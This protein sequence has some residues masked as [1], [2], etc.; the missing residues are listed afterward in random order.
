[1]SHERSEHR[2]S[3]D[4]RFPATSRRLS[5]YWESGQPKALGTE[6]QL[7]SRLLVCKPELRQSSA[8]ATNMAARVVAA[9]PAQAAGLP[10][11]RPPRAAF[12]TAS[13][14][15]QRQIQARQQH[16]MKVRAQCA[17]LAA[18][19][20]RRRRNLLPPTPPPPCGVDQQ[21]SPRPSSQSPAH[22]AGRSCRRPRLCGSAPG[23][24][25]A[26]PGRINGSGGGSGRRGGGA[27]GGCGG[28]WSGGPAGCRQAA[29]GR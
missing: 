24:P 4:R 26:A 19:V 2:R 23:P 21:R 17:C 1:M 28:C 29:R 13:S 25:A 22:A 14:A 3:R 18:R 15:Q 11:A 6:L 16:A 10:A 20:E 5:S 8:S 7:T 9:A 12:V 27:R